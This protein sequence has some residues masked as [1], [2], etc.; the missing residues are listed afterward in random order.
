VVQFSS[1]IAQR[2]GFDRNSYDPKVRSLQPG[3]RVQIH[4]D[5]WKMMRHLDSTIRIQEYLDQNLNNEVLDQT[6]RGR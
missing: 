1:E 5:E 2:N 6:L 4:D 3:Q